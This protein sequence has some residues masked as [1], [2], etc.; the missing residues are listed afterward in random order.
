MKEDLNKKLSEDS[1]KNRTN[2]IDVGIDFR[3]LKTSIWNRIEEME[4]K[5]RLQM[6]NFKY[7]LEHAG[8]KRLK[9]VSR[10]VFD[11]NNLYTY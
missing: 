4:H 7:I 6:E 2:L 1:L 5:Q 3:D 11:G 8:S 10:K 9:N